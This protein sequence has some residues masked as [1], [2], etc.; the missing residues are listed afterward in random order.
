[1]VATGDDVGMGRFDKLT[2]K[3]ANEYFAYSI[4]AGLMLGVLLGSVLDQ[5]GLGIVVGFAAGAGVGL[6]FLS[7][8]VPNGSGDVDGT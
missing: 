2:K 6:W 4:T 3:Q 8:R 7:K 5:V 1:M